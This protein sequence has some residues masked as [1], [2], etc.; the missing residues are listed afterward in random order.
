MLN[1]GRFIGFLAIV[2]VFSFVVF[3]GCAKPPTEEMAKAEKAIMDA[4][5][6]EAPT[7]VPELMK[8]AE[9]ALKKAKDLVVAKKYKEALPVVVEAETLAKKAAAG[10][11]EAKAKMK[12]DAEPVVQE[13]E[14]TIGEVKTGIEGLANTKN[15][16]AA[17]ARDEVQAMVTEWETKFN[18]VKEKLG[19][20][21]IKEA[22]EELTAVKD[23]IAA[24]KEEVMT[25]LT[26]PPAAPPAKKK[27]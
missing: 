26:P 16:A 15:K 23:E 9:D 19:G 4:V 21:K 8:K 3:T 1:R 17:A 18:A 25:K 13:I 12:K 5:Q 6:K 2:A 24:K 10:V 11:A 20:E 7:Y 14:G 22:V 27:K